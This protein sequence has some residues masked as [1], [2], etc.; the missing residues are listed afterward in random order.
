[1]FNGYKY[2]ETRENFGMIV[3]HYQYIENPKM[4]ALLFHSKT[5]CQSEDIYKL[6]FTYNDMVHN[7]IGPARITFFKANGSNN[8]TITGYNYFLNSYLCDKDTCNILRKLATADDSEIIYKKML[9]NQY[10][11]SIDDIKICRTIAQQFNL[12]NNLDF[13]ESIIIINEL[14]GNNV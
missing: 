9:D 8:Y 14:E 5:D 3:K 13:F 11:I 12:K 4:R 10:D 6:L 7:P 1:M 2:V